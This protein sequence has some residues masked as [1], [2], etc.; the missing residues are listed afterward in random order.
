MGE[1]DAARAN[2]GAGFYVALLLRDPTAVETEMEAHALA[3]ELPAHL[4]EQPLLSSPA[5]LEALRRVAR[6][7]VRAAPA[8]SFASA[9]AVDAHAV[10][11]FALLVYGGAEQEEAAFW[12]A[13]A[14]LCALAPLQ[15]P[16]HQLTGLA[17][18]ARTLENLLTIKA[19]RVAEKLRALRV[20]AAA[21]Y[22]DWL[23]SLFV[24]A[25]PAESAARVWDALLCEG[26]KV[27]VRYAVA[28]LK[29]AEPALLAA[30]DGP[31]FAT[32]LRL[33]CGRCHDRDDLQ[34]AAFERL[35]SLP[36]ARL[37]QL[38][39]AAAEELLAERQDE[40][41]RRASHSSNA[42]H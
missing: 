40:S 14:A 23:L 16:P 24:R 38:R 9:G 2:A 3:R 18:E 36:R 20:S 29:A 11:A 27:L 37:E 6:A 41:S 25:L 15:P 4:A 34:D 13:R 32:A 10:A 26:P 8:G 33:A 7:L 28:L 22:A 35:G 42:G 17:V 5:G 1:A 31:A 39:K 21:F 30:A 19:P 12:T